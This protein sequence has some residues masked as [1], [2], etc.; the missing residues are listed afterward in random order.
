MK[1]VPTT[2]ILSTALICASVLAINDHPIY[3]IVV[4]GSGL[5]FGMFMTIVTVR[6]DEVKWDRE[7]SKRLKEKESG[8]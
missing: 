5:F 7:E 2:I 8:E 3:G 6:G 1:W 4:L